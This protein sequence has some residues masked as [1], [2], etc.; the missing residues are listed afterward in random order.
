MEE[1]I[2]QLEA[3][4]EQ[5]DARKTEIESQLQDPA[6]YANTEVSIALQKELTDLETQI[7]KLTSQWEAMTEKLEA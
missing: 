3:D 4:L 6:T 2:A 7:E 1:Q 5:C